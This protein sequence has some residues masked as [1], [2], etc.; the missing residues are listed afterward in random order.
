MNKALKQFNFKEY[1]N[2]MIDS[3]K[4]VAIQKDPKKFDYTEEYF[5][6]FKSLENTE[7]AYKINMGRHKLIDEYYDS[8][9][10]VDIGIGSG[11]FIRTAGNLTIYG[12]D[13]SGKSRQYLLD[14]G[15]FFDIHSK[16]APYDRI[17][18]FTFWDSLEH[19]EFKNQ[20]VLLK[21][22]AIGTYIFVSMPIMT[23]IMKIKGSKHYKPNE[24]IYYFTMT[25]F[26][27]YMSKFGF[28]CMK[29]QDFEIKA[30]REDVY[31]FVF[32]K[33]SNEII[34]YRYITLE[35]IQAVETIS[36]ISKKEFPK[37]D[38]VNDSIESYENKEDNKMIPDTKE[39][40][41]MFG[42]KKKKKEN[43]YD[44]GID[45]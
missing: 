21:R 2:L 37:Y 24:H 13:I 1:D 26:Q 35:V 34:D 10:I 18:I 39:K 40:K 29:I 5:N 43:V 27:D 32:N 17:S 22:M 36:S 23:D 9:N 6:H 15:R 4:G 25:G 38:G 7:S 20:G 14:N 31:T 33:T 19:I 16:R 12:Y 28:M 42:R 8:N 44:G 30:G 41:R 11:D 3:G 45:E